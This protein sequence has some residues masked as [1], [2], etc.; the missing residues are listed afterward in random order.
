M[1]HRV[2]LLMGLLAAC[3]CLPGL[4]QQALRGDEEASLQL[5]LQSLQSSLAALSGN[6]PQQAG[7]LHLRVGELLQSLGRYE[8]AG[9]ALDNALQSVRISNGLYAQEQLPILQQAIGNAILEKNWE[10]V[11]AL[12]YLTMSVV[13]SALSVDEPRYEEIVRQFNSW[14]MQAQRNNLDIN[15]EPLSA[16]DAVIYLQALLDNLDEADPDYLA[17]RIQMT[18]EIAMARYYAAMAISEVPVDEFE[19]IGPETVTGQ[20]CFTITEDT[21]SGPKPVRVC[22]SKQMPNPL[23]FESRQ[24]AKFEALEAHISWIR[25]SYL[26]LIE[27][28]QA[29]PDSDPVQLAQLM[30]SLGDMNFL[31]ND[32]LRAQ[33]QYA[34]AFEVLTSNDVAPEVQMQLMG[35]PR[36]IS[37][38]AV[39]DMGLPLI[40]VHEQPSGIVSFDVTAEGTIRNLGITGS[41]TDL[42]EAN[43]QLITTILRHSV[44]R[45][46]LVEGQAVQARLELPAAQL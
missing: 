13:D 44:Y 5:E 15:D 28:L 22:E 24:K 45:P 19:S 8:E 26:E 23:F 43:Q 1:F 7:A 2:S 21:G 3:H 40:E 30:L 10:Q 29:D 14:K 36:E 38:T 17:R 41:G 35:Q 12:F 25:S 9:V 18:R 31:L 34:N 11:D 27:Q 20:N 32:S 16:Q 46:K 33:T 37:R 42:E 39:A 4:A 6:S